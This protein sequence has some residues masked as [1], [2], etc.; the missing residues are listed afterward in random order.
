LSYYNTFASEDAKYEVKK[1]AGERLKEND[2][3]TNLKV[4]ERFPV[5]TYYA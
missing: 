5:V 1:I 2:F 4:M 3:R